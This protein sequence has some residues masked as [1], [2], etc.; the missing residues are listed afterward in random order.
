[1]RWPH[2]KRARYYGRTSSDRFALY[3]VGVCTALLI[4]LLV[5]ILGLIVHLILG[6]RNVPDDWILGTWISGRVIH[7]PFLGDAKFSLFALLTV[8]MT[9]GVIEVFGLWLLN[10]AVHRA[11]MNVTE[12]FKSDIHRQALRLGPIDLLGGRARPETLFR[13]QIETVRRGL[14]RWWRAVPFA[15]V[16]VLALVLMAFLV[17]PWLTLVMLLGV[18]LVSLVFA[19]IQ[20]QT[21]SRASAWRSQADTA[22]ERLLE[23]LRLTPLVTGYGLSDAPG[24]P[25][26]NVLAEYRRAALKADNSLAAQGP[27]LLLLSLILVVFVVLVI[28]LSRDV[29][30]A[31]TAVLTAA[32]VGAGFPAARLYRVWVSMADANAAA[33]ELFT[34]L[35]REPGVSDMDVAKP[36]ERIRQHIRLH[37]V[38][39]A[40]ADGTKLMD[41]LSLTIPAGQ[42]AALVTSDPNTGVA[43]AGLLVRLYDPAAGQVIFD[44]QDIATLTVNSVRANALLVPEDGMLFDGTVGE[45]IACGDTRYS[46]LQ[47]VDAAKLARA[48][49]FI[50]NLPHGM[51]TQIGRHGQQLDDGQAFRVGL[52]RALLRDPSFMVILEPSGLATGAGTAQLDE[53]L[54]LA[55]DGRTVLVI[56][57]RIETLQQVGCVYVVHE[58][59]LLAHGSHAELLEACELYR[60]LSYVRF[61]TLRLHDA[62]VSSGMEL[63]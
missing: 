2:F 16:T 34:Y 51:T 53:A 21:S 36:L 59:K 41:S 15:A 33:G 5:L 61:S 13:Q 10:R 43:L 49:K 44:D 8:G 1:M 19:G 56:P 47:V 39:L 12:Q 40:D 42:K 17:E 60:H 7:W 6:G 55:A 50:M 52:A 29:T 20:R 57:S 26:G 48:H 62:E 18:V 23:N 31:G 11:A 27:A 28:G 22:H 4:P 54:R 24:P 46:S 30:V 35:E 25:F 9:I 3:T 32:A 58:G 63:R 45:N 14:V 38:T 37:D